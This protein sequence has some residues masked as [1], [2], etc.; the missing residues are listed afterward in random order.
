MLD[1]R[2]REQLEEILEQTPIADLMGY[3]TS[4]TIVTDWINT[5]YLQAYWRVKQN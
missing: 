5:T 2:T 4:K 3:L 1:P